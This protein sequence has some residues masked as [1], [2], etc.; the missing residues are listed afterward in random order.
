MATEF[1]G[2]ELQPSWEGSCGAYSF[3]HAMTLAGIPTSIEKSKM[4]CKYISPKASFIRK[5]NW[6]KLKKI[7]SPYDLFDEVGTIERGLKSG[8][9]KYNC[10]SNAITTNDILKAKTFLDRNV[11]LGYPIILSV[12]WDFDYEDEGHW[13]VCGGKYKNN[14]VI[15][16]SAP[17][18]DIVELYSWRELKQRFVWFNSDRDNDG[19]YEFNLIAVRSKTSPSCTNRMKYTFPKIHGDKNL[20]IWWGYYLNDLLEVTQNYYNSKNS[21]RLSIFLNKNRK[22]IVDTLKYW[23]RDIDQEE[24]KNEFKNYLIVSEAYGLTIPGNKKTEMLLS[25]TAALVGTLLL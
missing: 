15:I 7:R 1:I 19:Y 2:F 16:D 23:F 18:E 4:L 14:Y 10:T 11:K 8:I 3:G 25:F 20:Q 12:N 17:D 6:R 9:K 5:L 24:L 21:I 22:N 13:M